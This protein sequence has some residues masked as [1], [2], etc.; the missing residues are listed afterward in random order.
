MHETH[1]CSLAL[2]GEAALDYFGDEGRVVGNLLYMVAVPEKVRFDAFSPF[3]MT[4]S[5]L[6]SDGQT[7]SLFDLREK[8][9]WTGPANTCN[10]ARFA[11]VPVPAFALVQLLRGVAPVLVHD[12]PQVSIEWNGGFLGGGNY[13][14][15]IRSK[16]QAYEEITLVPY[17]A[18]WNKPWQQQRVHVTSVMVEQQGVEL[19]SA[20]L[21]GHESTVRQPPRRDPEGLGIVYP[22]SGPECSA[23]VPR[24][25]R[26]SVPVTDRDLIFRI[27]EV[28]HNPA[29]GPDA[30]QQARP[31]G[32][33]LRHAICSD[34]F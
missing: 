22:P 20:E 27:K 9:F 29:I 33:R 25:I 23:E 11:G 5:T 34:R 18:D 24:R 4:L 1:S 15:E 31:P 26:I 17:Q 3:G 10:M 19:Y 21:R 28:W 7:F 6:T 12:A 13:R 8:V 2:Q 14:I 16:H 32:T 30:F